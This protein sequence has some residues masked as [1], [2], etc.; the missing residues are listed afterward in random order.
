MRKCFAQFCHV[1]LL[2]RI[3]EGKDGSVEPLE[4]EAAARQAIAVLKLQFNR[5]GPWLKMR[6]ASVSDP[7]LHLPRTRTGPGYSLENAFHQGRLRELSEQVDSAALGT[8]SAGTRQR[9]RSR[10]LVEIVAAGKIKLR[11]D[12]ESHERS[13]QSWDQT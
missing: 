10:T 8:I 12:E 9:W 3:S 6:S 1:Q 5:G 7:V 11:Q 2:T 4:D 13:L